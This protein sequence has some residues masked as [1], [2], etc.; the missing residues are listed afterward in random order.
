MKQ[1]AILKDKGKGNHGGANPIEKENILLLTEKRLSKYENDVPFL[2]KLDVPQTVEQLTVAGADETGDLQ[3][4]A[5]ATNFPVLTKFYPATPKTVNLDVGDV[6]FG[7][8]D[9]ILANKP[10][11]V[12][13]MG[14]ITKSQGTPS[15]N[16]TPN[17]IDLST[18][19]IIKWIYVAPNATVGVDITPPPL[20]AIPT[21]Q[22]V[23]DAGNTA[24]QGDLLVTID[25]S[26]IELYDNNTGYGAYFDVNK[27]NVQGA[28]GYAG[29]E[30]GSLEINSLVAKT[31]LVNK[32][33]LGSYFIGNIVV[34]PSNSGTLALSNLQKEVLTN[35]P[36]VDADNEYT[37][38][39]NSATPI[40]V[41]IN[42]LTKDNFSCDFYNLGAGAVTFVNGTATVGYPDG[43]ILN[44]DKVCAL[45]RFMATTTY[46]L[47]GELV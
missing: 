10:D 38:F 9:L 30:D 27:V 31:L 28:F 33:Y 2:T 39:F 1:L 8:V 35:Y 13:G 3:Y 34:L 12:D 24:I 5:Y 16:Y 46:K 19:Y 6:T 15:L 25:P 22:Q 17:N 21:L 20:S 45:I 37:I 36:I 18:Q 23:V 43:T 42:T 32:G 26:Y 40:T 44:T 4:Y 7:R 14:Y 29:I 41:T 11:T 47:K